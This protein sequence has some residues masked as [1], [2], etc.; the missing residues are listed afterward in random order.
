M[1]PNKSSNTVSQ[2]TQAWLN[3]LS[4]HEL[5]RG[6][7]FGMSDD[8]RIQLQGNSTGFVYLCL[9]SARDLAGVG[10]LPGSLG[11]VLQARSTEVTSLISASQSAKSKC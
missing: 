11:N 10:I 9:C 8:A 1:P 7:N 4:L 2:P 3:Q 5:E 6:D